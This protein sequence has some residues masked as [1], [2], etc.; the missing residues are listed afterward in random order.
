MLQLVLLAMASLEVRAFA[1][2]AVVLDEGGGVICSQE[3]GARAEVAELR[4]CVRWRKGG[5]SVRIKAHVCGAKARR[6]R[7]PGSLFE[8][9]DGPPMADRVVENSYGLFPAPSLADFG[10]TLHS[11]RGKLPGARRQRR[12]SSLWQKSRIYGRPR[13]RS[14]IDARYGHATGASASP[15]PSPTISWSP[16][17]SSTIPLGRPTFSAAN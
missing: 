1:F 12:G 6:P 15:R 9:S 10:Q 17:D 5:E 16:A 14:Q 7:A 8:G 2:S 11:L 3:L 13:R 4:L